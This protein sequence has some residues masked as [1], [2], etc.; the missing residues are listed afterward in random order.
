MTHLSGGVS[1][2][3]LALPIS[4]L[5][6]TSAMAADQIELS[7]I[8]GMQEMVV[9]VKDLENTTALYRDVAKWEVMHEGVADPAQVEFWGLPRG[10]AVQQILLGNPGT[11]TGFLCLV[12][13]VGVDQQRIRF[14]ARP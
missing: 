12:R 5:A 1:A 10:V 3:R 7:G 2:R 8:R 14:S 13:F 4:A 6:A 11:Q 9:S